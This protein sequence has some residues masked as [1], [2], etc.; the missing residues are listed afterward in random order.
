ME[1]FEATPQKQ[2]NPLYKDVLDV[3]IYPIVHDDGRHP[4]TFLFKTRGSFVE[5][6]TI[7]VPWT[8]LSSLDG[9]YL[10]KDWAN[11][12]LYHGNDLLYTG[13]W[14]AGQN[15]KLKYILAP[16]GES[17]EDGENANGALVWTQQFLVDNTKTWVANAYAGK[18]VY[19]YTW[20][21]WVWQIHRILFN[22][23]NSLCLENWRQVKHEDVDYH[24]FPDFWETLAFNGGDGLYVVH[25]DAT[26][27]KA[28][29]YGTIIDFEYNDDK[30][31]ALD[32]NNNLLVGKWGYFDLYLDAESYVWGVEGSI[33]GVE[34]IGWYLTITTWSKLIT[35]YPSSLNVWWDTVVNTYVKATSRNLWYKGQFIWND[36]MYVVTD[37]NRFLSVSFTVNDD[38][39]RVETVDLWLDIQKYLD[40]FGDDVSIYIDSD[41]IYLISDGKI[42]KYDQYYQWRVYREEENI[43]RTDGTHFFW[44]GIYTYDKDTRASVTSK[45]SVYFG[46]STGTS[47]KEW[48]FIKS[49]I[50]DDTNPKAKLY[51][52]VYSWV[53]IHRNDTLMLSLENLTGTGEE[54]REVETSVDCFGY[55]GEF[56]I[57]WEFWVWTLLCGYNLVEPEV[58]AESQN[59]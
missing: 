41:F 6:E 25:D 2:F 59:I 38:R 22:T 52:K 4:N 35:Y 44:D 36:G 32:E 55:I 53:D 56:G 30:L 45:L 16:N 37:K 1:Y 27:L 31:F 46:E 19:T 12:K 10:T 15:Y 18:Y 42:L 28:E 13:V 47:Y 48:V 5:D 20:D 33:V 7:T 39:I 29:N 11:I 34:T 9:Y 50:T 43:A 24:I 57:E 58:S 3:D 54:L 49:L 26:I 23:T 21:V 40:T 8:I 51:M 17:I 14:N